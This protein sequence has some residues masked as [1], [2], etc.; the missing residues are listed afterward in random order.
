MTQVIHDDEEISRPLRQRVWDV[1]TKFRFWVYS[2]IVLLLLGVGVLWPFMFIR[3]P[4]G[5]HGVMYRYFFGGTVTDRIWGEGLHVIPPWDYLTLYETRLMEKN[6]TFSTLSEEG[7]N[8]EVSLSIRYRPS[9]EMLGYLHQDVGPEYYNRLIYPEVRSH[10]RETFGKRSAHAVYSSANDVIQEL[11]SITILGRVDDT[12]TETRTDAYIRVQE[13]KLIGIELP[14]IVKQAI[15]ERY[16]QEQL[17]HEYRY[18]LQRAEDE[19]ERQRIEAA[20]IRD[21]NKIAAG[22]SPDI[23]RWRD[24]DATLSL[25]Q[26]ENAKVIVLGGNDTPLLFSLTE[27]T[28]GKKNADT[29]KRSEQATPGSPVAGEASSRRGGLADGTT[30]LPQ[31]D[32]AATPAVAPPAA[33]PSDGTTLVPQPPSDAQP[34]VVGP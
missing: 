10:V 2:F 24:I 9:K 6:L 18:K 30:I 17:M 11:R 27:P 29:N 8:L 14:D 25:A 33:T 1:Y 22:I 7:L 20:G 26:S 3:I 31:A 19:A 23:L 21:Y 32:A 15:A 16:R 28:P 12:G 5:Y 4:T 13:I 34:T